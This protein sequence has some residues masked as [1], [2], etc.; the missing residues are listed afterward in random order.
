MD[1]VEA[2]FKQ[3]N[4]KLNLMDGKMDSLREEIKILKEE[5][6]TLKIQAEKNE[7][8]IK[9]GIMF[10][11]PNFDVPP[12]HFCRWIA[13]NVDHNIATIDG[14]NTFH[15]MGIIMCKSE[16]LDEKPNILSERKD[17]LDSNLQL[18]AELS[19]EEHVEPMDTD[20]IQPSLP[21]LQNLMEL[22]DK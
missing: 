3:I 13:D 10:R 9:S 4:D 20:E 6:V 8:R 21:N 16:P 19:S 5:N 22:Y 11:S 15:G 2:M 1:R 17:V 14:H 18:P 7:N 12:G